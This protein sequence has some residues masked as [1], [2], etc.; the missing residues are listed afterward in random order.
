MSSLSADDI[1][2][3]QA[4]LE[5]LRNEVTERLRTSADSSKPVDLAQPI[6]RLA[7]VDAMQVQQL[8]KSQR[9]R[10]EGQLQMI[11]SALGRIRAGTYG[12]C[13]K[14]EEAIDVHRLEAAP[15]TPLCLS[16]RQQSERR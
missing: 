4:Q 7:R 2:R 15:E 14:C 8:A 9:R 10:D 12:E 6:G 5:R 3:L 13:L 1:A 16:C 11:A